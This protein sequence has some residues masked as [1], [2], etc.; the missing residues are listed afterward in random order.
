MYNINVGEVLALEDG[1]RVEVTF[2]SDYKNGIGF[3]HIDGKKA[4]WDDY[5]AS[6]YI[7]RKIKGTSRT[8]D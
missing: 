3:R 5:T 1:A 6:P 8:T 4:G 2:I 7:F